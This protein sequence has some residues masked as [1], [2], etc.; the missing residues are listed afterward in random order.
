MRRIFTGVF[1]TILALMPAG[2]LRAEAT[3]PEKAPLPD[4]STHAKVVVIP[5]R[6]EIANPELYILRRGVKEAMDQKVD[7]IVLDM[8]TP[9]GRLDVTFEMLKVERPR[10]AGR[11]V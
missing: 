7:T 10:P 9:G 6:A 8:E 5:I 3:I 11:V 1:A 4:K 2:P